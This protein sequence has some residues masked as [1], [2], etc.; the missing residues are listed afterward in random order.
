[1]H[2][3][4]ILILYPLCTIV[5]HCCT[6]TQRRLY[7]F[8]WHPELQTTVLIEYLSTIMEGGRDDGSFLY[9]SN[10]FYP[11]KSIDSAGIYAYGFTGIYLPTVSTTR[12]ALIK[13]RVYVA[14]TIKYI[15]LI[16]QVVIEKKQRFG[17]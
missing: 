1:V 8:R 5:Y 3:I 10:T 14:I 6:R 17:T 13:T 2:Y 9:L 4:I 15:S 12:I 16:V 11:L 7:K